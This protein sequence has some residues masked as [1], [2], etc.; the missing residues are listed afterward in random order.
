MTDD[1]RGEPWHLD[2][3]VNIAHITATVMVAAAFGLYLL[4]QET[5]LVVLEEHK[6]AQ[7]YRDG[8]QDQD[9]RDL[10]KEITDALREAR[11]ELRAL[12]DEIAKGRRRDER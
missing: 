8:R 11:D 6:Q 3:R 10:K 4:K 5:R 2:K 1:S 7:L 9:S 12:R